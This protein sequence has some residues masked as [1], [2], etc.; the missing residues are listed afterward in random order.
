M[1]RTGRSGRHWRTVRRRCGVA[2]EI[3]HRQWITAARWALGQTFVYLMMPEEAIAHLGVGLP[4]AR[5]LGS[6]WWLAH[7]SATLAQA[8]LLRGDA[9]PC[10]AGARCLPPAWGDAAHP[11]GAPRRLD[12]GRSGA[13]AAR[14]GRRAPDRGRL[15]RLRPRPTEWRRDPVARETARRCARHARPVRGCRACPRCCLH[16][17]DGAARAPAALAGASV[18]WA[19]VS[20]LAAR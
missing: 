7:L 2:S 20:P 10:R 17:G 1:V 9:A 18:T 5:D 15:D 12:V 14:R 11:A 3:D 16:R 4:L 6:A 13:R 8:H 19:P